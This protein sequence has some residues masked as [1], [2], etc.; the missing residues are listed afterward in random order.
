MIVNNLDHGVLMPDMVLKRLIFDKPRYEKTNSIKN[1][2]FIIMYKRDYSI[3]C[4]WPLELVCKASLTT[5][6]FIVSYITKDIE[7]K[8]KVVT[9][10]TCKT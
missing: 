5:K 8:R 4:L 10:V 1:F 2:L 6:T 7:E 3:F 9:N